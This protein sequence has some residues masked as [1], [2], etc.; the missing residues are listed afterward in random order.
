MHQ[1]THQKTGQQGQSLVEYGLLVAFIAVV[2]LGALTV[3]GTETDNAISTAGTGIMGQPSSGATANG[4]VGNGA[5]PFSLDLSNASGL[6]TAS[7]TLA[8]GTVLPLD[9]Y[10]TA[11]SASIE[12]TGANGTTQLLAASMETLIEELAES[13]KLDVNQTNALMNLANQGHKLAEMEFMIE[14]A[15]NN[16]SSNSEF[17]NTTFMF[18]GEMLTPGQISQRLGFHNHRTWDM[19]DKDAMT[20]GDMTYS[21]SEMKVFIDL[22]DQA[23][24]TGALDDPQVNAVINTL[25]NQIAQIAGMMEDFPEGVKKSNFESA[26][27]DHYASHTTHMN[28][29]GICNA[30][31]GDD[32]GVQCS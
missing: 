15:Y 4:A 27:N 18:D 24:V 21:D 20:L 8:D 19:V 30:G 11:M 29:K 10:P 1:P 23:V 25:S 26:K 6:G 7:V 5:T 17:Q 13:G 9:N 14:Q 28:A 12:T 16:A 31:G 32:I 22:Y 2:S 3:L